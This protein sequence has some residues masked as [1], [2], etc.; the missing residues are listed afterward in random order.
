MW[1]CVHFYSQAFKKE[2][3]MFFMKYIFI[4]NLLVNWTKYILETA[5][6]QIGHDKQKNP[7]MHNFLPNHSVRWKVFVILWYNDFYWSFCSIL[8]IYSVFKLIVLKLWNFQ[9]FWYVWTYWNFASF[10]WPCGRLLSEVT[11]LLHVRSCI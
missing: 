10:T 6:E 7:M 3:N 4:G 2:W 11:Y 9:S 5:T 1:I 8:L